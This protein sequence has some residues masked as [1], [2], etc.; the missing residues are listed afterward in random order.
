MD[1]IKDFAHKM[2][3]ELPVSFS[4]MPDID[5]YM[6][7]VLA[8]LS[9]KQISGRDG[10]CLT[11][12]MINNYIKDGLVPRA[13]GK[14]YSREH[15][16]YLTLVARLEQGLSGKDLTVLLRSYIDGEDQETYYER[17]REKLNNAFSEILQLP[18]G[19]ANLSSL[20]LE[21]ALHSYVDKITCEYLIDQIAAQQN[22]GTAA[23]KG[24]ADTQEKQS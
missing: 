1:E 7:P 22:G 3:D 2:Q 10:D 4:A 11:S 13:N 9:R 18:E 16:V 14:K 8:F 24:K 21:F 20:A 23:R 15:L 19:N 12:A 5:L 17:F 6:D